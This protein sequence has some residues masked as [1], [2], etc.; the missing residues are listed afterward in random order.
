MSTE[1]KTRKKFWMCY[2]EGANLPAVQHW[3][4]TAVIAEAE[5]L[6]RKT[7]KDVFLLEANRWVR[8][9]PPE[10]PPIWNYTV[11]DYGYG[12]CPK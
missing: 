11:Q 9:P 12:E 10:P 8:I 5:R 1:K 6:A 3:N 2:V 7:N 4:L